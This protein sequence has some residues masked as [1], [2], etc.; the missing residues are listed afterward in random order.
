M[1]PKT[2]T[3]QT[4]D[5]RTFK[6]LDSRKLPPL[7]P[8]IVK[9]RL[10]RMRTYVDAKKSIRHS[11]WRL[12]LICQ[13]ISGLTVPQ[14]IQQ[15]SFCDKSRAPLVQEFLEKAAKKID[16]KDALPLTKLEVAECFVTRG[17]PLKRIRY[18]GR[19]R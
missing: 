18:M 17:T 4:S 13:M 7:K 6:V 5:G 8:H 9:R 1:E 2:L 10:G 12:N 3:L 19:G 14:A 11:P 15:L 16:E